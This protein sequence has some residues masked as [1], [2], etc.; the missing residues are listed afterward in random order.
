MTASECRRN[1]QETTAPML[2]I[3]PPFPAK[4]IWGLQ[5]SPCAKRRSF[6][7]NAVSYGLFLRLRSLG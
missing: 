2:I 3:E 4:S 1:S 6:K 5:L 7:S